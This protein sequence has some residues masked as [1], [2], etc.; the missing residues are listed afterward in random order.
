MRFLLAFGYAEK[1]RVL[2]DELLTL[3]SSFS[4]GTPITYLASA[5]IV[6]IPKIVL[7]KVGG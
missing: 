2:F 7:E 5:A 4:S 3:R 6:M 1:Y